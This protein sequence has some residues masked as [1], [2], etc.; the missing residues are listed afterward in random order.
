MATDRIGVILSTYN[1]PAWLEKV[2]FGYECQTDR[3]FVLYIA[4][5]GSANPTRQV[6]E[7]FVKRGRLAIEHVWH[8][9]RGFRKCT[10]LNR[11]IEAA[12][13][14][15]L[16]FSDGD[17]IPRSD[18]VFRHRRLA[19]PG[20]YLSGG[21]VKLSDSVSAVISEADI[22]NGR[23]FDARWLIRQGQPRSLKLSK[24]ARS[25]WLTGL[26]NALTP[27]RT[28]WNG[29]NSSTWRSEL[30]RINGFDERMEYGGEDREL[31]ERLVNLG[32]KG[33]Q[34]RYRAICVHL[35]H[36]RGYIRD[37]ALRRNREIRNHT[38]S[39]GRT[40]TEYGIVKKATVT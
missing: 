2:L 24:L 33:R 23:A 32:M 26:L 9:D 10:I 13:A 1:A 39:S 18:F 20:V 37:D 21:Y 16:I 31:G 27:T 25:P 22:V 19:A 29:M 14:D 36:A 4:D 28:S 40:W 7:Q 17:C 5:D 34:I 6:I 12:E 3:D 8:E 15:Y 38:A 11:A 35:E 30:L